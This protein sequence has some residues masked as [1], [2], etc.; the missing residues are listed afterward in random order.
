VK[1]FGQDLSGE[2][3]DLLGKAFLDSRYELTG[4][5]GGPI[6]TRIAPYNRTVKR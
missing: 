1:R 3:R 2:L 4:A 6:P 5:I